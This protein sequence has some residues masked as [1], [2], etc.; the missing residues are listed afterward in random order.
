M[1]IHIYVYIYILKGQ[2]KVFIRHDFDTLI[3]MDIILFYNAVSIINL[4]SLFN[5]NVG[6][7]KGTC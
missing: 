5:L 1:Y 6:N 7:S 3:I 4:I 2:L